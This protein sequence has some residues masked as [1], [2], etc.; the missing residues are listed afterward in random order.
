MGGTLRSLLVTGSAA[1]ALVL[2]LPATGAS[3]APSTAG[4]DVSHPQCGRPLPW[5]Q[6]F[7]VVGVNGGSSTLPNPCLAAQLSWASRSSGSVPGQRR[8]Q[9]YL[10]TANPGELRDEVDTWPSAPWTPYGTCDSGNTRACSWEYG[11]ERAGHSLDDLFPP[12]AEAAGLDPDPG[13][14]TWWLDV[15]TENTWQA[16][17]VAALARNRAALE[18]MAAA[19]LVRGGSVGL[20]ATATQFRRIAGSVPDDSLLYGL[21]SWLAGADSADEA[22]DYCDRPPLARGG[23]VVLAQYVRGDADHDLPCA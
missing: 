10:N 1:L 6:A 20:Y 23:R 12:A 17:S 22:A 8:I 2:G 3:A 11:W 15:E 7:G 19:V 14:Y 4:A 21:D 18:G 9:L 16:G 13:G 5:G